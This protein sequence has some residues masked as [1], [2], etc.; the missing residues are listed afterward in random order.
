MIEKELG[1]IDRKIEGL[2]DRIVDA[3]SPSV[4]AAYERRIGEFESSKLFLKEKWPVRDS[5]KL[6]S[7]KLFETPW[8]FSQVIEIYEIMV[9]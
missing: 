2:L 7:T 5:Q 3:G 6:T 1:G 4:I 8:R 9:A